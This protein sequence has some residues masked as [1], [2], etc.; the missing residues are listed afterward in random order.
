MIGKF[1]NERA[2]PASHKIL[3]DRLLNPQVGCA[4]IVEEDDGGHRLL[5]FFGKVN[6]DGHNVVLW[7]I[8][9][10]SA[11][12]LDAVRFG[13][14]DALHLLPRFE[15]DGGRGFVAGLPEG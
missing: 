6:G 14:L 4:E 13:T 10:E 8:G 7:N 9:A 11:G 2:N 3:G 1:Q 12:E 5:A 15:L